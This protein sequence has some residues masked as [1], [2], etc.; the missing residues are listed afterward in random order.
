MDCGLISINDRG[1]IFNTLGFSWILEF[2][3]HLKCRE[4]GLMDPWTMIGA[5]SMSSPWTGSM[6]PFGDLIVATG[7]GFNGWE[8][9]TGA[10]VALWATQP[11]CSAAE[12]PELG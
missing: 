7:F 12:S 2:F 9:K 3:S 11:E 1:A 5:R 4:P 10:A 8:R 6:Y